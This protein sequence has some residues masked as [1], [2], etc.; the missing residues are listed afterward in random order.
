MESSFGPVELPSLPMWG[1][2]DGNS[3]AAYTNRPGNHENGCSGGC[4]AIWHSSRA[5]EGQ[6]KVKNG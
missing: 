3:C 6:E 2:F 4:A 5:R 1:D